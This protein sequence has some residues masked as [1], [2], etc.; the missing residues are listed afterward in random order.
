MRVTYS[1]AVV[2]HGRYG[3]LVGGAERDHGRVVVADVMLRV[4]DVHRHPER[5]PLFEEPYNKEAVLSDGGVYDN[6]A[7]EWAYRAE[8]R[9]WCRERGADAARRGGLTTSRTSI[10]VLRLVPR[11]A[12]HRLSRWPRGA[13]GA[14]GKCVA[15]ED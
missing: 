1:D 3:R 7:D 13:L 8:L 12:S 4:D 14:T 5:G 10:R 9:T 11:R 6:M 2:G 15:V